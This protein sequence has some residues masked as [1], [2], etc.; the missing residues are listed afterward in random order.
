MFPA[1]DIA[2]EFKRIGFQRLDAKRLGQGMVQVNA[3]KLIDLCL[4][5]E[6]A[7]EGDVSN[8]EHSLDVANKEIEEQRNRIF[9]LEEKLIS[10]DIDF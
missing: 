5:F 3:N 10:A 6:C 2:K 1:L 9:L 8:L 4:A 7:A